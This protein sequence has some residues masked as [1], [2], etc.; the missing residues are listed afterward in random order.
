MGL[1]IHRLIQQYLFPGENGTPGSAVDL[2]RCISDRFKVDDVPDAFISMP[3]EFGGLGL[4]NALAPL[5]LIRDQFSKTPEQCVE[6]LLNKGK[7]AYKAAK[8]IHEALGESGRRHRYCTRF[9]EESK[10]NIS[11]FCI[12]DINAFMTYED[13]TRWRENESSLL[14]E[15]HK[16]LRLVPNKVRISLDPNIARAL[17]DFAIAN[18]QYSLTSNVCELVKL[19]LVLLHAGGMLKHYGG[20][21]LVERSLL[22]LG[23]L[24]VLKRKI[25]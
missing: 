5:L 14:L 6:E 2:Q 18:K 25:A 4:H 24:D 23:V 21:G 7:E 22:P 20:L 19:W 15:K 9:P 12:G 17:D 10:S 3:E 11:T 16:M 8:S 1:Q 13:F